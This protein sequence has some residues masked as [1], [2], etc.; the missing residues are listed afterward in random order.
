MLHLDWQFTLQ[1][2]DPSGQH[3]VPARRRR[4]GSP[5]LDDELVAFSCRIAPADKLRDGDLRRF[6]GAMRGFLPTPSSTRRNTVSACR[7]A[8]AHTPV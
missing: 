5:M 8:T 6:Y 7:S 1:D 2:N 3:D 4:R